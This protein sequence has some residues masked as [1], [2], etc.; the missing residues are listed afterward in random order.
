MK[1]NIS[2]II[3]MQEEAK[4]FLEKISIK[5]KE[6]SFE[7]LPHVVYES[8]FE[9]LN[10]KIFTTQKYIDNSSVSPIGTDV[11]SILT[12]KAIE[13]FSIQNKD[14]R[15]DLIINAGTAG[16]LK[17]KN[18]SIG[19]VFIAKNVYFH[20]R[21]MGLPGY[22]EK[23]LGPYATWER[24]N[25]ISRSLGLKLENI[26]TG[27]SFELN[28]LDKKNILELDS[29]CK[30]MEA[31]TIAWLSSLYKIPFVAIKSITDLI[32]KPNSGEQFFENLDH[33]CKNLSEELFNLL[34][35][36]NKNHREN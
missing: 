19:D 25:E 7:G 15:P 3:T 24:S 10:L 31:G 26:S 17:E 27:N 1:K 23:S 9:Q 8:E 12:F 16:G 34:E 22:K 4:Y 29:Y 18:T 6:I 5:N 35:W 36:Y 30:E 20:D 21:R 13:Q 33:A 14:F 2:I 11:A 32:D 28:E